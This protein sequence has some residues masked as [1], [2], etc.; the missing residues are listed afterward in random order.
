M[1]E[2]QKLL[3]SRNGLTFAPDAQSATRGADALAIVTEWQEFRSPDFDQ[4]KQALKQPVIFDGRNLY[5]PELLHR[6]GF[7]Y[8]GVGRGLA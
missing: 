3:G 7:T 6:A 5:N 8:Y 2:A 4:L 1:P